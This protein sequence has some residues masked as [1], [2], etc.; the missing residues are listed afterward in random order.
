MYEGYQD[1]VLGLYII[2]NLFHGPPGRVVGI[3]TSCAVI[4]QTH[5]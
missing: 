5:N 2:E 3:L 4:T 1:P